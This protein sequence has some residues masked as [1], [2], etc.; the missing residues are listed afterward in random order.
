MILLRLMRERKMNPLLKKEK[1]FYKNIKKNEIER[2]QLQQ[3]NKIWR[4]LYQNV[5]FYKELFDNGEVP[6]EFKSFEEFI[7]LPVLTREY[8]NRNRNQ[9]IN[10]SKEADTWGT[11]GGSTGNP[12]KFPKWNSEASFCTPAIWYVRDFYG[13]NRSDKMF[14]LWGHSHTLGKGLTR[15][16]NKLKFDIGLPL[17]GF[18][19]YSAYDLSEKKLKKAGEEILKFKPK[20]IIGYSKAL[21]MLA[22]AN[23]EKK[24]KFHKLNLKVVLGAAEGFDQ[25]EDG[26]YVSEVFG[27]PVGL[28]YASM[29]T[30]YIAQ[31]HPNGNYRALYKNHIIECVDDKGNPSDTGRILITSL[32]PRAFPLV[33][34]E[35][36]DI[37]VNCK[38]D[39]NSVYAF[40]RIEGRN[41]DFLLLD[42]QTPIHS[43][44]VT[45]AIKFSS[46]ITSYQI[47]Y[48]KNKKYTIY[49]K[50]DEKLTD[51]DFIKIKSR[52]NQVDPR[53][54]K[55][56][57]KQVDKLKQTVAGKT[58][59]LIEECE[60]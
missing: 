2:Y 8:V 18:K 3:F 47:R 56:D 58:N 59:W 10:K 57:I 32:Y 52:L 9:F 27:C 43:E 21:Y 38:K 51:K 39:N 31:T 37:I 19:R 34:Y 23:E 5:D 17:V 54:S 7:R 16:K 24:E 14:R 40:E 4:E 44:G 25:I 15:I 48:T 60:N 30:N 36:G 29:E 26:N 12:L 42:D 41:N 6:Y 13:V 55:L 53:L 35:L 50:A 28:Q 20:Y 1:N 46:I 45:H 22:K 33:R 49:V 11:T